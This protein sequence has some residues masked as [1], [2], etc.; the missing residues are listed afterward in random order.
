MHAPPPVRQQLT[1]AKFL[2]A[3]LEDKGVVSLRHAWCTTSK[4]KREPE[5]CPRYVTIL[6]YK[7]TYILIRKCRQYWFQNSNYRLKKKKNPNLHTS[8]QDLTKDL[9]PYMAANLSLYEA[10]L[11][12]TL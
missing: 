2:K 1:E 10:D 8:E 11:T 7:V 6:I 9:K 4:T 5:H 3:R 12:N